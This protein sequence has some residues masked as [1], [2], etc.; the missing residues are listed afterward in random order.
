MVV[1]EPRP[2]AIRSGAE[3]LA[4]MRECQASQVSME[5]MGRG[6]SAHSTCLAAVAG[7]ASRDGSMTCHAGDGGQ[8]LLDSSQGGEGGEGAA[9]NEE[10]SP[11]RKSPVRAAHKGPGKEDPEAS[12]S[13]AA[14]EDSDEE[15]SPEMILHGDA[16]SPKHASC[17]GS[18][19]KRSMDELG[20]PEAPIGLDDD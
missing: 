15:S 12:E 10:P 9:A 16:W 14:A 19:R 18:S 7:L 5:G 6:T 13:S 1:G 4:L 3:L 2:V 17:S 11:H 20:S 8:G